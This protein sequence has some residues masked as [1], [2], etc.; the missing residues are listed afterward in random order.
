MKIAILCQYYLPEIGA[1]PARISELAEAWSSAGHEVTVVTGLPNHPTGRVPAEYRAT[2]FKKERMGSVEV[3]RNWLYATPNEGF[4]RKTLSHLSFMV[5]TSLLSVPRL[6]HHDVVIVS[7]PSFFVALSA[8]MASRLFTIPF[9]FEVRDLWPGS[10]RDV[11]I[12]RNRFLLA[13]LEAIELFFYRASS[14]VVT[15]THA[16]RRDIVGRGIPA[17]KVAVVTNGVDTSKFLPSAP[18]TQIRQAHGLHDKFIVLYIGA[19]GMSQGMTALINAAHALRDDPDVRFVFAGDG[20]HKARATKRARELHLANVIFLPGQ[21]R[22][23]MNSWYAA[24]DAVLVPLRKAPIFEQFVP[25]KMFEIM[26]CAR[27]IVASVAGEA[28]RILDDSSAAIVVPPENAE[29]IAAAVRRLKADPALCA[30]MGSA[31]R[32]YVSEHFDRRILAK[33]Y[34]DLLSHV[35]AGESQEAAA[36]SGAPA[37]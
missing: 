21:A 23:L 8:Y 3:W 12:M 19:H 22:E 17:D 11:G 33:R 29:A 14:R 32:Q 24:A 1:P 6:R 10:F 18:A 36:I 30:R 37:Q 15:V 35:A 5:S 27:P 31:G 26:A 25:S 16:F 9:V 7:S 28:A 34:L 2:I 13:A 4:V 20:A